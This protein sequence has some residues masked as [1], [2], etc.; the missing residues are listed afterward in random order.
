MGQLLLELEGYL[1][2]DSVRG[3]M[4]ESVWLV[5][6]GATISRIRN[7]FEELSQGKA[8]HRA[9]GRLALEVSRLPLVEFTYSINC[10]ASIGSELVQ[11][12]ADNVVRIWE[13][14]RATKSRQKSYAAR[15]LRDLEFAV[16]DHVFVRIAPMKGVM[17][18]FIGIN[19]GRLSSQ[20]MLPSMVVDLL[21]QNEIKDVRIFQQRDNVL[22]AFY[23]SG[24]KATTGLANNVLDNYQNMSTVQ[25]WIK[26]KILKYEDVM[27]FRYA[28]VGNNPFSPLF[29][30]KMY[31]NV[32]QALINMQE[33]LR[34]NNRSHIKATIPHYTDVLTVTS[35]SK[36]SEADFRPDVKEEM[37]KY[38]TFLKKHD[39]P[40]MYSVFPIHF[41]ISNDVDLDFAFMDNKSSHNITDIN[42]TY[43][44]AFE[45]LYDSLHW[46]LHKAGVGRM[47]IVIG[48]IGWPTDSYN[49]ANV[50]NA[51]RFYRTFLPYITSERGTPMR[52]KEKI[53]V[54][55]NTL[56]DEN[57][58]VPE[59]GAYHRHWGI[60]KF[61]G[62][63]K[64][65]I[66]FSG[67]G[68]NVYPSI[69]KGVVHMPN[70][71]CV[72]NKNLKDPTLVESMKAMSC[73][74]SDCSSLEDGGSCA[75]LTYTDKVSYAFNGY[76]QTKGQAAQSSNEGCDMGGLGMVVSYNPSKGECVFP[77]EILSAEFAVE[78]ATF[79]AADNGGERVHGRIFSAAGLLALG[80]VG[81]I[82]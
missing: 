80:V 33:G 63:P 28:T 2:T 17:H 11:Q 58:M 25:W 54:F 59:L 60:Y 53:D 24:I 74:A 75:N 43:T 19:W 46:A 13:K 67:E 77:V 34:R 21:L 5:Q 40:F 49:G 6:A 61:N 38:V 26:N 18:S 41:V 4:L 32:V 7:D 1:S 47:K 36:P 39:A 76:F 73:N 71:W 64:F 30:K 15:R 22:E 57:Q 70:R 37:V 45:L 44:N 31:M 72:F 29:S 68:R 55:L 65:S 3:L 35:T 82:I 8:D 78:G 81:M 9:L 66:D 48:A 79:G 27:E 51:Q 20:T 50:T 12:S 52:P 62:E 56:S 14:M 42:A 69:G 16:G 10:Q 23:N